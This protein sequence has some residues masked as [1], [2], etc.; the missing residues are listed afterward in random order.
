MVLRG[1]RYPI[2]VFS[3]A[4]AGVIAW[5]ITAMAMSGRGFGGPTES[6]YALSYEF[7]SENPRTFTGN[8]Y[9][10]GPIYDLLGESLPALRV[11][12]VVTILGANAFLGVT[13]M[14]WLRTQR[15]GA[16]DTLWWEGTG[17]A[18]VVAAGG[19]LLGWLPKTPGYNDVAALGSLVLA[20][21]F[22][23]NLR[24]IALD[25]PLSRL[26]SLT[27]GF[28]TVPMLFAKFS[29][30]VPIA[31]VLL[32]SLLVIRQFGWREVSQ[33][34]AAGL[35]GFAL[36]LAAMHAFVKP[37]DEVLPPMLHA[38]A[39]VADHGH[40][41]G[42]LLVQYI[43]DTS[44]FVAL[45]ILAFA[46]P[47]LALG[48]ALKR[49]R[50]MTP[51]K[52]AA[53]GWTIVAV[54][55]LLVGLSGGFRSGLTHAGAYTAGIGAMLGIAL[56]AGRHLVWLHGRVLL[57]LISLP[58]LQAFGTDNP[59]LVIAINAVGLWVCAA[60]WICTH[61]DLGLVAQQMARAATT[62]LVMIALAVGVTG[63]LFTPDGRAL[64]G[65]DDPVGGIPLLS[66]LQVPSAQAA[67]AAA[68]RGELANVSPDGRFMLAYGELGEFVVL[69][70]GRPLA[71]GWFSAGED[72]LQSDGL[73]DACREGN[74]WG[75]RQ[76][77]VLA[78]RPLTTTELAAWSA[79]E[80]DFV[81]DYGPAHSPTAKGHG[82]DVMVPRVSAAP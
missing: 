45:A 80:I 71:S 30:A 25:R 1:R 55:L 64:L 65:R 3:A 12:R 15:P 37:I 41:V 61:P 5:A 79:C 33:H 11:F 46:L 6:Y 36:N 74:P 78:A 63:S 40:G 73:E 52:A 38:I 28:L 8:Q 9:V 62:G 29:T 69:L 21:L 35:V 72:G 59:L 2:V 60:V 82:F 42:F 47:G 68:L 43:T 10:Y 34:M 4:S 20:G 70:N 50:D 32:M 57:L 26:A 49:V 23:I 22:L 76:P 39:I 13:F 54:D 56:L 58:V 31:A 51:I 18:G 19:V 81:R 44:R 14:R 17:V 53:I 16:P 66:G 7:R 27:T 48:V 67:E 24:R 75:P 77:I